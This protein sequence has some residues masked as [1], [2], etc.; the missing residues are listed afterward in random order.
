MAAV[1]RIATHGKMIATV[2]QFVGPGHDLTFEVSIISPESRP[3][4]A[5]YYG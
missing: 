5:P 4:R 1:H 3:P 2:P